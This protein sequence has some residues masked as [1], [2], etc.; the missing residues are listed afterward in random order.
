[1]TQPDNYLKI[2]IDSLFWDWSRTDWTGSYGVDGVEFMP[3]TGGKYRITVPDIATE[4]EIN[5]LPG[6]LAQVRFYQSDTP[7]T[8]TPSPTAIATNSPTPTLQIR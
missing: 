8:A 1:M 4:V 2:V 5:I 3:I 7:P 6:T